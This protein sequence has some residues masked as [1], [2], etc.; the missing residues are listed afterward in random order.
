[1]KKLFNYNF[2]A[3][4]FPSF[5]NESYIVLIH[6]KGSKND[7]ANYRG[8]S[9]TSCLGK[10]FNKVINARLLEYVDTKNLISYI[11]L[12]FKQNSRTSD[13]ILTLKSIIDFQKSKKKKVFTAF[14]D[15]L[16][17]FDTVWR[18]G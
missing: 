5:W 15:L 12:G 13:H 8:I 2:D 11:Q 10:L 18:D 4:K 1:M 17:A 16:K 14:I 9:L 7:P 6:K 3:G